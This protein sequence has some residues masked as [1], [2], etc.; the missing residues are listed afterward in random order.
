[1][2][3][4]SCKRCRLAYPRR[5]ARI[6][7]L[8]AQATSA[9]VY[10]LRSWRCVV[11]ILALSPIPSRVSKAGIMM[12]FLSPIGCPGTRNDPR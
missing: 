4:D 1:M 5:P 6:T 7:A 9:F 11:L 12:R 3:L 10:L 8:N 2:R